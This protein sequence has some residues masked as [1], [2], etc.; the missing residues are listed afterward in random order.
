MSHRLLPL[1]LAAWL[2]LSGLQAETVAPLSF[3]G[4]E[5][6]KLDWTTRSMKA[7]DINGDGLNDFALINN[8]RSKIEIFYQK[9]EGDAALPKKKQISR[10]RWDPVLEDARFHGDSLSIGYPLFDLAVGDLNGDGRADLAY[11]S[12]EVPL[13]I[14]YQGEAG[15]WIDLQEFD[16]FDALGW[17][18]TVA[19]RDLDQDGANEV[20]VVSYDAIRIFALGEDARL[21]E[22]EV[23]YLTGEN[24]FNLLITDVTGDGLLDILYITAS[25]KQSLALRQQASNGA[26]G[27]EYR[28][29]FDRPI[30]S[31]EVFE[32]GGE[33]GPLFCSVDSRSGSLEFFHI[34]KSLCPLSESDRSPTLIAQSQSHHL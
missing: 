8:D 11:S 34:E 5:V 1:L 28:F 29:S 6:L 17:V 18:Q 25:G 32:E 7:A 30:R 22:P 21:A 24:P 10:N 4:P 31:L 16:S 33:Q 13:T 9:G 19:I 12:R 3:T 14:R 27:P 2:G 26:F 20:V 23:Y 15:V